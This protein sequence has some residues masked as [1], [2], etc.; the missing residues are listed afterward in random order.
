M[1]DHDEGF[2]SVTGLPETADPASAA[3]DSTSPAA[4][5]PGA[6]GATTNP[7]TPA[8][9]SLRSSS[10]ARP[11]S[12]A[13]HSQT[14]SPM[15]SRDPSPSRMS[16]PHRQT[17]A[18]AGPARRVQRSRKNSN[19]DGS[20][21]RPAA[22]TSQPTTA[23]SAAAIQ[24]ALASANTPQLQPAPADSTRGPRPHKSS[25]PSD[26]NPHW[27]ISPRIKSP[28][29]SQNRSR[30]NSLR[31]QQHQ[32]QQPQPQ[33]QQQQP[34]QLQHPRPPRPD[35]PQSTQSAPNIVVERTAT[36]P[37]A[38]GKQK[39]EP[40]PSDSEDQDSSNMAWKGSVRA[41]SGAPPALETVQEASLPTSPGFDVFQARRLKEA[42]C[43]LERG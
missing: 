33:Q 18:M 10:G 2:R 34:Q 27:P 43:A 32:Q 39:N 24:R 20:P 30:R 3:E 31:S 8:H 41:P 5:R 9:T 12:T 22:L 26:S 40:P 38:S 17:P 36:P 4:N 42:E 21:N 15:S 6:T 35:P 37:G 28:P 23:P 16:Q 7:I 25:N 1:T 11:R 19:Q 29:P 13:P 14:T